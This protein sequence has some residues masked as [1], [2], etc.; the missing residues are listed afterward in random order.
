MTILRTDYAD[1]MG[2]K[3]IINADIKVMPLFIC[4]FNPKLSVE[5]LQKI[6]TYLTT[7]DVSVCYI[8]CNMMEY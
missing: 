5:K 1:V 4:P 2:F 7:R 8:S 3:G 6:T